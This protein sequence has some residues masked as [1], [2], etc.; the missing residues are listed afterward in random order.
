MNTEYFSTLLLLWMWGWHLQLFN[1]CRQIQWYRWQTLAGTVN[2]VI[3]TLA[4][5]IDAKR[6]PAAVIAIVSVVVIVVICSIVIVVL[7]RAHK[8][9]LKQEGRSQGTRSSHQVGLAGSELTWLF[10]NTQQQSHLVT[11]TEPTWYTQQQSH[12]VTIT[13]PMWSSTNSVAVAPCHHHSHHCV[14]NLFMLMHITVH[15]PP[16]CNYLCMHASLKPCFETPTSGSCVNTH[17]GWIHFM[18]LAYFTPVLYFSAL[19]VS[20]FVH[21]AIISSN[22]LHNHILDIYNLKISKR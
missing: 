5:A 14:M 4:H 21:I 8:N 9:Q 11:I 7:P 17:Y 20:G 2:N 10:T 3:F 16:A 6:T 19:S 15:N 12:L 22:C 18:L 13:E 1:C